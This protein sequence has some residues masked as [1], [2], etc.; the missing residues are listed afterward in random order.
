MSVVFAG[1]KYLIDLNFDLMV[2]LDEKPED[3]QL[4]I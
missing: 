1:I 2:A 4:Y 3:Q